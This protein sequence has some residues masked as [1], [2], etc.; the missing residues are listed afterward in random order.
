MRQQLICNINHEKVYPM[1]DR[2]INLVIKLL[3]VLNVLVLFQYTSR[4]E[5]S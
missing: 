3:T 1:Y 5:L 2:V 4:L